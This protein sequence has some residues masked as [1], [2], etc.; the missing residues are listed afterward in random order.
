MKRLRVILGAVTVLIAVA[1]AAFLWPGFLSRSDTVVAGTITDIESKNVVYLSKPGIYVVATDEGFLALD[2]DSRHVGDRVLYCSLDDMFFSP[3]HG[4]RFDRQGRYLAGPAQGDM[5]RYPVSVESGRVVVDTSQGPELPPRSVGSGTQGPSK[6][7]G[8]G[9][10]NP[11]G[12]YQAD[13]S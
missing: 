7:S 2:D 1:V 8:P 5:G 4:E 13:P 9:S 11:S 3:A 12:F 10:E 6:C